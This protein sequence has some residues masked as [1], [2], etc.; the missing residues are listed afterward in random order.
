M[1]NTKTNATSLRLL[2]GII[3][4]A[5]VIVFS[6]AACDITDLSDEFNDP[7]LGTWKGVYEGDPVTLSMSGGTFTYWKGSISKSGKYTRSGNNATLSPSG[8]G[9][10]FTVTL[11][12]GYLYSDGIPLTKQ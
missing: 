9:T 10:P 1:K 8:G 3:A 5:A 7:F 6:M 12:D 11:S 4:L 2:A